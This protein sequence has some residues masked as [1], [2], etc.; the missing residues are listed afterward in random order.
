M[1]EYNRKL[2][3]WTLHVKLDSERLMEAMKFDSECATRLLEA[4][5]NGKQVFYPEPRMYLTDIVKDEIRKK[6]EEIKNA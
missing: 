5:I 1:R 2:R 3:Q 6:R 4:H